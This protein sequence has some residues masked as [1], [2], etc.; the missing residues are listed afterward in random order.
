MYYDNDDVWLS[1]SSINFPLS[2]PIPKNQNIKGK[3]KKQTRE[4]HENQ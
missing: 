1:L 4:N 3:N 2:Q